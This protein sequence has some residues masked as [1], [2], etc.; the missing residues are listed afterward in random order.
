MHWES[1]TFFFFSSSPT[2]VIKPNL[3]PLAQASSKASLLTLGCGEGK[4]CFYCRAS[5]KESGQLM[6]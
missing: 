4:C 2:D 6:F 1:H 5:S 3:D